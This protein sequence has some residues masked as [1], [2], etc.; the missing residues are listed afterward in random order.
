MKTTKHAQKRIIQ[1]GIDN[2]VMDIMETYLPFK[3]Q[4]QSCQLLLTR[5]EAQRIAK[6][7]RK[8][9]EKI[10]KHTGVTLVLDESASILITA[11]RKK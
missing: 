1:R 6:L 8:T 2:V 7:M 4:N 11:Y 3:Y 10:E 5:K 9:A